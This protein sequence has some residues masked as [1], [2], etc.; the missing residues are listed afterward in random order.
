MVVIP[1]WCGGRHQDRRELGQGGAAILSRHRRQSSRTRVVA[2]G[3]RLSG[4]AYHHMGATSKYLYVR[5]A[6][7]P[8]SLGMGD[9][10]DEKKGMQ[11]TAGGYAEA[12]AK[13]NHFAWASRPTVVQIHG[14]GPFAIS[15]V[16]PADDP[17]GKS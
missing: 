9:K 16:N 17:R 10:L 11:L 5:M 8:L 3:L 12:P 1:P 14:Q 4:A 7:S 2:S 6:Q 13:M 15:Y